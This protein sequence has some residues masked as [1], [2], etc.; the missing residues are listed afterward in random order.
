MILLDGKR[1]AGILSDEMARQVALLR[2]STGQVPG[3]GILRVGDDP[4][5]AVY[6]ENKIKQA[7][8]I[9]LNVFSRALP[10][11]DEQALV[12]A[13]ESFNRHP[14]IHGFIVQLPLPAGWNTNG[15]LEKIDPSKDADGFHPLNLG[16]LLADD[17][18]LMP[19]T[20]AGIVELLRYYDIPV[21]GKHVVIAGRSRIVGR[22]LA[23][24]LAGRHPLGNATVTLLH[25]RTENPGKYIREA[26]VFVSAVGIP[27]RWKAG[28]FKSGAVAV[29]VG[30]NALS[31]GKLAGDIDP[32][33]LE[34][35]LSAY[36]PV[37]GGVGPMTVVMLLRNT[38][39]LFVRKTDNSD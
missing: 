27:Q 2:Q 32:Q 20:P 14:D 1:L 30:I 10:D 31:G 25:S 35:V 36:T 4:A 13:I 26:D 33:G 28:M 5:G 19:A 16:R 23:A 15:L 38:I 21:A 17:F 6:V 9:G 7:K 11:D 18:D 29:D 39:R 3:L 22:P 12:R 8:R 37:P 34:K 24:V